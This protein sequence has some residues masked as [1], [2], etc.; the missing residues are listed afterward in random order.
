MC[1]M[2]IIC[3]EYVS[4][5]HDVHLCNMGVTCA[6]CVSRVLGVLGVQHVYNGSHVK[7]G[8]HEYRVCIVGI[9]FVPFSYAKCVSFYI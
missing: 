9:V 2:N 8:C 1:T 6:I 7:Y 3:T 4:C 5:V